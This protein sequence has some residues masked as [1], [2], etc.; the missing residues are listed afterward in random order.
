MS[1]GV[2]FWGSAAL[3][4]ALFAALVPLL[5][6]FRALGL[7]A[8]A[9][10]DRVWLLTVFCAGVLAVLMAASALLSSRLLGVRDVVEGGGVGTALERR[11]QSG[12]G[13]GWAQAGTWTLA[14]GACLLGIYFV[15]W[16]VLQ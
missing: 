3:A 16:Q 9:D 4:A 11:R 7:T 5:F 8:A 13:A 10:R 12:R 1:R 15:L 2:R 14:A 6:P